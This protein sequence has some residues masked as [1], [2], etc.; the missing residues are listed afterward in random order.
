VRLLGDA[1]PPFSHLENTLGAW[2]VEAAREAAWTNAEVLWGIRPLKLLSA[3]YLNTLDGLAAVAGKT[4]L[5]PVL[6]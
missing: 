6:S 1:L 4:L 3:R 5:S 2:S